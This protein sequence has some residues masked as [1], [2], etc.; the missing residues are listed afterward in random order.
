MR[1]GETEDDSYVSQNKPDSSLPESTPSDGSLFV[2]G[3]LERGNLDSVHAAGD[4]EAWT[5]H[6]RTPPLT[7]TDG[8]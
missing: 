8:I 3:P 7:Q 2:P 5:G 1:L 6:N 4:E